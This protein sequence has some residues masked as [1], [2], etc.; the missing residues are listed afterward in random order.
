MKKNIFFI[1]LILISTFLYSQKYDWLNCGT[2]SVYLKRIQENP[3][4]LIEQKQLKDFVKDYIKHAEKND[5]TYIIPMVFHVLHYYG[6]ENI[7][8]EQILGAVDFLNK[9]F[10]HLRDDT[11]SIINEFKSLA[12]DC[13]I[14]FRLAKKDPNGNCTNGVTRTFSYYTFMG[15]EEAKEV[16]GIWPPDKYLNVWVVKQIEIGAAGYSYYPG[17][18]PEGGDGVILLYNY[19]GYNGASSFQKGSALSHEVGHY[20]SLPHPW[21]STNQP[22]DPDNCYTDDEIEDTPNTIGHKSCDLYAETCGSLDN[23][24]NFMDLV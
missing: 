16:A 10:N 3:N 21:G 8:Y 7:S 22:E 24:Q 18:A 6:E 14:E 20:L 1:I 15:G 9:D 11:T 5:D 19:V 12:A 2:D 23:V 13:N 4:I 17:T